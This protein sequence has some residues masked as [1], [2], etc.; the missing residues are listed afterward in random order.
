ME[1]ATP[2][3]ISCIRVPA[4]VD[5]RSRKIIQWLRVLSDK[6]CCFVGAKT[7][8]WVE[9]W[10]RVRVPGGVEWIWVPGGVQ[11]HESLP[12]PADKTAREQKSSVGWSIRNSVA[13]Q[14][15]SRLGMVKEGGLRTNLWVYFCH[16]CGSCLPQGFGSAT[17]LPQ[18]NA[19]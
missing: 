18:N 8:C 13:P 11:T 19:K 3:C 10:N 5:Q 16:L 2:G 9:L 14:S 4:I 6:N 7:A 15:F 1:Q 17:E 12:F